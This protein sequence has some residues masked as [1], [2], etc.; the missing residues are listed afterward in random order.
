[1]ANVT[2]M[3]YKPLICPNWM[4]SS[5][6]RKRRESIPSISLTGTSVVTMGLDENTA[7]T[8]AQRFKV[9]FEIRN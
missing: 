3:F 1:M 8:K 4:E 9:S 2:K 5:G 7:L 6:S